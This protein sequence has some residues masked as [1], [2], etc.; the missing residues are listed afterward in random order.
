MIIE[1]GGK[2]VLVTGGAK[3]IGRGIAL[4]F[5]SSGAR[6]AVIDVDTKSG[7]KTVAEASQTCPQAIF[8][9]ANLGEAEECYRATHAVATQFGGIDV[10]INNVGIQSLESYRT[11]EETSE[12]LWDQIMAVNLKSHFLMA[13]YCIPEMR[14]RGG[15]VIINVAS[16][17]GLQSQ[18]KVPAYAASKGGLLSLTRQMSIDYAK[19][20]IRVLA[21]NPGTIE[22]PLVY[23]AAAATGDSQGALKTWATNQPLGRLGQPDDIGKAVVFLASDQASFM[24]GEYICVDGGVM[25]IGT[26]APPVS[27]W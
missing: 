17:Q 13:K 3:G 5:A 23:D 2:I 12:Q 1:Y 19:E 27:E 22:T 7:E 4:Q 14:K 18:P 6:V 10:L 26:W 25:A 16:I 9:E 21:V 15:G 20:R 8:V 11:V 24:T